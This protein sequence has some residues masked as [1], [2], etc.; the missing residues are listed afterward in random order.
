M[1]AFSLSHLHCKRILMQQQKTTFANIVAKG[2]IA[3]DEH[4]LFWPQCFQLYLTVDLS[5]LEIFQVFANMFS[6]SSA[7]DLLYVEEG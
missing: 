7:A 2:D 3:H 5:F 4:F 1:S 6:K